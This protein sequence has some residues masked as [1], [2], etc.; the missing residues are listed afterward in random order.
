MMTVPPTTDNSGSSDTA[1]P[2]EPPAGNGHGGHYVAV[3]PVAHGAIDP[4]PYVLAAGPTEPI[5]PAGAEP[6]SAAESMRDEAGSDEAGQATGHYQSAGWGGEPGQCGV[7]CA[8]GTTFDNFD[9]IAEAAALLDGH[10]NDVEAEPD[11][12]TVPAGQAQRGTLL[13]HVVDGENIGI[14]VR[15]VEPYHDGSAVTIVLDGGRAEHFRVDEMLPVVDQAEA[16]AA[17]ARL[18][19][20]RRRAQQIALLRQLADLAEQ[21]PDLRLPYFLR[22]EGSITALEDLQRWAQLLGG[23][24]TEASPGSGNWDLTHNFG[25]ER[26]DAPIELRFFHYVPREA[27]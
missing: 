1:G 17:Q 16:R 6:D 7:E 18:A 27:R 4:R 14:E 10:I 13:A 19:A 11:G 20:K 12:P 24:P 21:Q 8:C 9:T 15:H 23:E 5:H 2:V 25:G 22:I 26:Y 3:V